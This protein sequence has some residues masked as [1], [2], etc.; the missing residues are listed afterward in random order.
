MTVDKSVREDK[1][2]NPLW[3]LQMHPSVL[4]LVVM[5]L[6]CP[7]RLG[8]LNGGDLP[9]MLADCSINT[10][11]KQQMSSYSSQTVSMRSRSVKLWTVRM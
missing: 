6:E 9:V 3:A 4:S 2:F 10:S 7:V 8:T 11:P 1:G 5:A